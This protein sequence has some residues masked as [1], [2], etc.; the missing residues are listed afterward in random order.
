MASFHVYAGEDLSA[1]A[2]VVRHIALSDLKSAIA[3]GFDDFWAMPSHL[4]F[5][6]IVY[7]LCGALLAAL[8]SQQNVAQMLFPLASGFALIG[9]FAAIGLYEMSRRRE[10]G[11]PTSWKYAL[12]VIRS[13]SIPAIATLGLILFAIF[14]CWLIAAQALY[15]AFYGAAPPA[16]LTEFLADVLSTSRGWSLIAAG[17]LVG[18]CFAGVALAIS[19]VS[20][21]LLLDRDAGLTSAVAT[22]IEVV[23]TN[24]LTMAIWGLIVAAALVIASLPAFL[25]LV[26]AMPVLGHATWHLYRLAVQRDPTQEHPVAPLS[27][28]LGPTTT[29]RVKPHSF[30]FPER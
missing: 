28:T 1:S 7:P 29:E 25:G 15:V 13:P 10:L 17:F 3:R 11:L 20:F 27:G 4:L 18:G 21:P 16:S 8:A 2:P 6:A 24:P 19:A 30:L 23:R 14:F 12:D 5:L 26:I 9:P 22:S